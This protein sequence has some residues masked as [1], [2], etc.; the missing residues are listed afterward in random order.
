MRVQKEEKEITKKIEA[1]SDKKKETTGLRLDSSLGNL[2][3]EEDL[4]V[5]E[6]LKSN[7]ERLK[8]GEEITVKVKR[9]HGQW[10]VEEI[11]Q[12]PSRKQ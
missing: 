1:L 9:K 11:D 6:E 3:E 2:E 7:K 12:G 4:Q 10:S 8:I 5:V